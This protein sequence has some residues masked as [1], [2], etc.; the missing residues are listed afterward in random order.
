MDAAVEELFERAD[1]LL[2]DAPT[3]LTNLAA[4]Y[5]DL[6]AT[7]ANRDRGASDARF[8]QA[9]N[10]C[11]RAIGVDASRGDAWANLAVSYFNLEEFEKARP[12]AERAA[13]SSMLAARIAGRRVV[14]ELRKMGK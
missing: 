1:T 3:V 13:K 12:A 9:V 14:E 10:V 8:R 6:G 2:P 4:A 7:L 11:T 5:I